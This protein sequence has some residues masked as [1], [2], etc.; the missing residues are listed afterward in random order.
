MVKAA[1]IRMVFFMADS[2]CEGWQ[3]FGLLGVVV[4][5]DTLSTQ[6]RL[7]DR[8]RKSKRRRITFPNSSCGRQPVF[9]LTNVVAQA[10]WER[11]QGSSRLEAHGSRR[12]F[13][14]WYA[15]YSG[16]VVIMAAG[17]ILAP[18]VHRMLYLFHAADEIDKPNLWQLDVWFV[19]HTDVNGLYGSLPLSA[20]GA[21]KQNPGNAPWV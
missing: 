6:K 8:T 17:V 18:V 11:R 13:S 16:L 12:L 19:R 15:L 3:L 9:F 14:G 2:P 4:I 5:R 21:R 10:R 7:P 20:P 1:R